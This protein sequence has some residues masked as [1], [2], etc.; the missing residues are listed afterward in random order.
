MQLDMGNALSG[1]ADLVDILER[2]PGS[3]RHSASQAL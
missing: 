3:R 2:Y 1:G